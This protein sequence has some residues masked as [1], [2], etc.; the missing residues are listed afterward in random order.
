MYGQTGRLLKIRIS[1]HKNDVRKETSNDSVMSEYRMHH[2]HDS[3][4]DNAKILD[5]ER[6][7]SKRL[8]SEIL[9]MKLLSNS[10]R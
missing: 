7:L 4:S 9:F 3:N 5:I 1:E 6:T 2:N 10:L 8:I